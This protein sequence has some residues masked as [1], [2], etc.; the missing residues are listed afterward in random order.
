MSLGFF[1]NM[2]RCIGCRTCQVAC[3]DRMSI[4]Q[5]GPRPRRVDTYEVGAFPSAD[6][7]HV[8]VSCNHC[9]DPA[10]VAA[11]PSRAMHIADDGTV[12]HDDSLCILCRMC[13]L[14]CPYGAPQLDEHAARIVKCDS[15]KALRDAGMKPTC[16]DACEQR[17][18]EFGDLDELRS[19]HPNAELVSEIPCIGT[20]SFTHPNLLLQPTEAAKNNDFREVLM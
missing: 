13:T 7:F 20:A 10:C 15:C 5:A 6:I 11:C 14:A 12:M 19:A 18:L 2:E 8:V 17:A 9:K 3:K 1:V 4:Q 16:V